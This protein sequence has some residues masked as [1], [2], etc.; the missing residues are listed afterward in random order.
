MNQPSLLPPLSATTGITRGRVGQIVNNTNFSEINTLLAQGH[1]MDY[2]ASH[3]NMD[4]PLVWALRLERK[5]GH[6]SFSLIYP[7]GI[8]KGDV[9]HDLCNQA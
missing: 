9:M 3:N 2:I 7:T 4:L 8:P 5:T 1:D 6:S